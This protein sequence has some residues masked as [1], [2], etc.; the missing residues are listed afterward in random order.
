[1]TRGNRHICEMACYISRR[2][3][4]TAPRAEVSIY[5]SRLRCTWQLDCGEL[6]SG[7]ESSR[8]RFPLGYMHT[9]IITS[10]ENHNPTLRCFQHVVQCNQTSKNSNTTYSMTN[11][12][13]RW[14]EK[15]LFDRLWCVSPTKWL[16]DCISTL[17]LSLQKVRYVR[18]Q[19]SQRYSNRYT[20]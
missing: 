18:I 9:L 8:S 20:C 10:Y 13:C 15:R 17:I 3:I 12:L 11:R 7:K 1:M 19:Q 6:S 16:L 5:L 14:E 4:E 2:D